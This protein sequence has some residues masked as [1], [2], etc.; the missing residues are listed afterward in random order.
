VNLCGKHGVVPVRICLGVASALFFRVGDE[1]GR[2]FEKDREFHEN[3]MI[4]GV[5]HVLEN[6]CKLSDVKV[7]SLIKRYYRMIE[8]GNRNLDAYTGE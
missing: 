8:D 7:V 1:Q 6:V 5:S 3:D 2:M 4:R